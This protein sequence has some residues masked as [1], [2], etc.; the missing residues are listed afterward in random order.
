MKNIIKIVFSVLFAISLV[1][2]SCNND[3]EWESGDIEILFVYPTLSIDLNVSDNPSVISVINSKNP[4]SSITM[5]IQKGD[6]EELYKEPITKFNNENSFSLRETPV[7][8]EDM[9]GMK[10]VAEDVSGY[11]LERVL[12]FSVKPALNAPVITFSSSTVTVEEGAEI[13]PITAAVAGESD[14]KYVRL[15]RVVNRVEYAY[16]DTITVFDNPKEFFFD[17]N[18]YLGEV[19]FEPGI[20]ALKIE[21]ADVYEKI[22]I[23]A[24]PIEY[25]ELPAPVVTFDSEGVINV[26]EFEPLTIAGRISAHSDLKNI[27]YYLVGENVE[28]LKLDEDVVSEN[29]KEHSFNK[30]INSIS[31][32]YNGFQV[33]AVDILGK[34]T[35]TTKNFN[36]IAYPSP[37]IAMP[38]SNYYGIS[39]GAEISLAGNTI[40]SSPANIT[41]VKIETQDLSG[42]TAVVDDL[43]MNAASY[44]PVNTIIAAA[45]LGSIIITATNAKGKAKSVTIPV[46]VD[47]IILKNLILGPQY[48]TSNNATLTYDTPCFFSSVQKKMVTLEEGYNN[49]AVVD[50]GVSIPSSG[51][52]R[53]LGPS[54]TNDLKNRYTHKDYGM[55]KWSLFNETTCLSNAS[56]LNDPALYYSYTADDIKE[57]SSLNSNPAVLWKENN[58][59]LVVFETVP[60]EG[61]IQRGL[62]MFEGL[63]PSSSVPSLG[64]S[65]MNAT[66]N[67][68]I[69]LT[70]PY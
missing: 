44:T 20:T 3:P 12:S 49:Q 25:I 36:V 58:A 56:G 13:P 22:R 23:A 1:I 29:I 10:I 47:F 2:C 62:I 33:V 38:V 24:L 6:V 8:R 40:T 4:L 32:D 27:T 30:T 66:F 39:K 37:E 48:K 52:V 17:I 63:A 50:W 68:T 7:Y 28:P 34:K 35:V 31:S 60:R 9:T 61:K 45:D 67:I 5:Y 16:V 59:Y 43:S 14:L 21:A 19:I 26:D 15:T 65:N 53:I 69:K 70:N 18:D 54:N 64:S 42:N 55:Q 41:N 46:T 51:D 11:K 57:V